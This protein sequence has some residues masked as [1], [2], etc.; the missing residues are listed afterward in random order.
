MLEC[1]FFSECF[2]ECTNGIVSS[3]KAGLQYKDCAASKIKSIVRCTTASWYSL[4]SATLW[5]TL[6]VHMS[7]TGEIP[8][9]DDE[10][11]AFGFEMT[12]WLCRISVKQ[13]KIGI[14]TWEFEFEYTDVI[15]HMQVTR[16]ETRCSRNGINRV[17]FALIIL[18]TPNRT[19]TYG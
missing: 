16:C 19:C 3:G 12:N 7:W 5:L 9:D 18:I 13:G 8:P 14:T 2:N 4:V 11:E 10:A 1:I 17:L 15:S 6:T